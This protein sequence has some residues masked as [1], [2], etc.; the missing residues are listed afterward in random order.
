M[1]RSGK[2]RDQETEALYINYLLTEL[3]SLRSVRT[4]DLGLIFS[5]TDRASEVNKGFIIHLPLSRLLAQN[6]ALKDRK[7]HVD[8]A[9]QSLT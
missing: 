5:H 2:N 4:R 3:R 1:E 6:S 8:C 9:L 7:I